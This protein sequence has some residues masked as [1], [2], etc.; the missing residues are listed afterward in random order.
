MILRCLHIC[1]ALLATSVGLQ[2]HQLGVD[3]VVL[4]ELA[5]HQYRLSY[6]VSPGTPEALS[7][8]I[9]PEHCQ[10][11]EA[12]EGRASGAGGLLFVSEGR[13]LSTGDVILL[14]WRRSGVIFVAAWRDGTRAQQFFMSGPEGIVVDLAQ[15]KAGGSSFAATAQRYTLL[16]ME[17]IW[18]GL[19]HLLFI[20]GLLLL[21]KGA[22]RLA[23]TIT[24]FTVA[25]CLTLA[26]SVLGQMRL[27][28]YLVDSL[29]ALSIVFLA[30]EN[31]KAL[32][33][34]EGLSTRKPWLVS[35][36]FGLVHGLGFA[37]ALSSLRLP[38][39][40]IPMALLFF[41]V[42]VE[43]GQLLFLALWLVLVWAARQ[44]AIPMGRRVAAV[45]AYVLGIV[46]TCWFLDRLVTMFA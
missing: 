43:L 12:A 23:L 34:E 39:A 3:R 27:P 18:K 15:L 9:L 2:A 11:D 28:P 1:V 5:D 4:E 35:F 42:G 21:V 31:V 36:G 30:V 46:A 32:R 45:A 41:N 40:D 26:L 7:L 17:H 37:G 20:A 29:V 16:G 19:D 10:W 25:H 14:P 44:L 13:A 8:P 38:E 24:A 6:N 22:R 33:G